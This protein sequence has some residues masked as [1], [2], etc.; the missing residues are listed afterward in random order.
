MP[1]EAVFGA[2]AL[3]PACI[4]DATDFETAFQVLSKLYCGE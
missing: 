4:G 1:R 2:T 3:D